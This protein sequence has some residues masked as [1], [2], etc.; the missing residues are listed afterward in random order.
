[1]R[2]HMSRSHVQPREP[3]LAGLEVAHHFFSRVV[4]AVD[5]VVVERQELVPGVEG[6]ASSKENILRD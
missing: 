5:N 1:M 6:S 4:V 2:Q 3:S